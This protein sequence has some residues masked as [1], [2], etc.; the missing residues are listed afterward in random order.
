MCQIFWIIFQSVK[1]VGVKYSYSRPRGRTDSNSRPLAYEH[2]AVSSE[3]LLTLDAR[4]NL[5]ENKFSIKLIISDRSLWNIIQNF[6]PKTNADRFMNQKL[7]WRKKMDTRA[8]KFMTIQSCVKGK[9]AFPLF[10]YTRKCFGERIDAHKREKACGISNKRKRHRKDWKK[11][12]EGKK[13]R[14]ATMGNIRSGE[15]TRELW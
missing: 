14:R 10:K 8:L 12:F 7:T 5:G 6:S 13:K 11:S 9:K 3:P 2:E 15:I 1:D 4:V